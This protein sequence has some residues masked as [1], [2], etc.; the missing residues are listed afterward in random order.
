MHEYKQT[1]YSAITVL[2]EPLLSKSNMVNIH[3]CMYVL[4]DIRMYVCM[5]VDRCV[6]INIYK[7][8][9]QL[10]QSWMSHYS[11][12]QIWYVNKSFYI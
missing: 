1:Y 10:L 7:H 8:I 11:V 2:D 5:F 6:C 12:N 9:I 3:E 4:I